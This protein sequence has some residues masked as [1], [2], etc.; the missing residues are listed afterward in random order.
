MFHEERKSQVRSRTY[1]NDKKFLELRP[2]IGDSKSMQN[3]CIELEP[4]LHFL[5]STYYERHFS[6]EEAKLLTNKYIRE[7]L[8]LESL[9]LAESSLKIV[10]SFKFERY[11]EVKRF[12][13]EVLEIDFEFLIRKEGDGFDL[14]VR[15]MHVDLCRKLLKLDSFREWIAVSREITLEAKYSFSDAIP[16]VIPE[17]ALRMDLLYSKKQKLIFSGRNYET[18]ISTQDL[19]SKTPTLN[20]ELFANNKTYRLVVPV[21]RLKLLSDK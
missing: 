18:R 4:S 5:L 1:M 15:E 16:V 12:L 2:Y 9:L 14:Y 7:W 21:E 11:Q 6:E 17:Q 10:S 19:D 13:S 3:I 20:F 8:K